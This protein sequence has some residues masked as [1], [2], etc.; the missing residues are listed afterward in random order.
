[1]KKNMLKVLLGLLLTIVL[2]AAED[3]PLATYVATPVLRWVDAEKWCVDR[4]GHLASIHSKKEDAIVAQFMF[5]NTK[6]NYPWLGGRSKQGYVMSNKDHLL[7]YE[8]T[9]GTPWD[10]T[11]SVW[12]RNDNHPNL[13]HYYRSGVWGTLKTIIDGNAYQDG[14]CQIPIPASP[15]TSPTPSTTSTTA[16]TTTQT[17]TTHTGLSN[18][19]R[20]M[21]R[22]QAKQNDQDRVIA[23]LNAS[24]MTTSKD[25]ATTQTDLKAAQDQLSVLQKRITS[26]IATIPY[27]GAGD[28]EPLACDATTA[29]CVPQVGSD[30]EGN[31]RL[32][33][34]SGQIL[35]SSGDCKTI[36]PC[37]LLQ[38]LKSVKAAVHKLG[39][40]V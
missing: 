30:D 21:A 3:L 19:E 1:M 33:S 37:E 24:L 13:L 28:G 18:I 4:G 34:P 10:Y 7:N 5:A 20:E 15:T 22:L 8:W 29:P 16:T 23:R 38:G 26:A 14:V 35:L 36:D 11:N 2:S 12:S 17:Y 25:L 32:E 6:S 27:D 39:G 31:L 9:D 40:G